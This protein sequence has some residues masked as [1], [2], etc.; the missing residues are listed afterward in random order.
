MASANKNHAESVITSKI[1]RR[2]S[3]RGTPVL[4]NDAQHTLMP[5]L[6]TTSGRTNMK[7]DNLDR[8]STN[9]PDPASQE[10]IAEIVASLG[11]PIHLS[12]IV[13]KYANLVSLSEHGDDLEGHDLESILEQA[14][15]NQEL[16]F[17]I[18]AVDDVLL[19]RE[20]FLNKASCELH[21]NQHAILTENLVEQSLTDSGL[22]DGQAGFLN[23][24]PPT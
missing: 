4:S 20:G 8:N 22:E 16:D 10:E 11:I 13:L 14:Q 2:Y 1:Y 3:K 5:E 15:E 18:L 21:M 17:W 24:H 19:R 12:E 6:I 23:S 7:E 9:Y